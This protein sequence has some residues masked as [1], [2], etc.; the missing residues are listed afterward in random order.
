[1][2]MDTKHSIAG[3]LLF[4]TF[5]IISPLISQVE[6]KGTVIKEGDVTVIKN[7][8]DPLHKIPILELNE[9]LSLGGPGGRLEYAF[10]NDIG[11]VVD[12]EAFI[13]VLDKQD[14]NIKVFNNS[15]NFVRTIGRKGQG[16]GELDNPW[17]LSVNRKA[18]ELAV[19]QLSRRLSFFKT[20]GTFIRQQS[21]N[22]SSS[23]KFDSLG[24]TYI[25]EKTRS[26]D[27]EWSYEVKKFSSFGFFFGLLASSPGQPY[28]GR[29]NPF[30]AV[31]V[32]QVDKSDNLVYG[33]PRTYEILFFS[34]SEG[35]AFKKIT[36]EY[37]P[38]IVTDE[39]KAEELKNTPSEV[40]T[41]V[42]FPKYYPAYER[43]FLSDLG[44]IFVQTWE[45]TKDGMRL[46]DIFDREGRF[47]S[48]IP[49][50]P[51]GIEIINGKYYALEK[52][53]DGYQ[54]IKRYTVSWNVS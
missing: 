36:R 40:Q 15:G 19:L 13:Y 47:I 23:V 44:H 9:D 42:V 2:S 31:S 21:I 52:D 53:A 35:K 26:K 37:D 14:T 18:G 39:D 10:G 4:F 41:S 29:V 51:S 20:D 38:V 22:N 45:K 11:F 6:W 27:G 54:Y 16:P 49:L 50:R 5:S 3:C 46:Y 12:N 32:F 43:F 1:M 17:S 24:N 28:S 25:R 7:P 48:R 8:K 34:A 30:F 33:D